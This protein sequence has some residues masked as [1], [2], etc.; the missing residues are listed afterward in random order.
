MKKNVQS[1]NKV[2]KKAN[3]LHK[4]FHIGFVLTCALTISVTMPLAAQNSTEK[5]ID[6]IVAVVNNNV[7]TYQELSAYASLVQKQL[8]GLGNK[9]DV[10]QPAFLKEILERLIIDKIQLQRAKDLG[11]A[12]SEAEFNQILELTTQQNKLSVAEYIAKLEKAGINAKQWKQDQY[13]NIILAR[14][15][16]KEVD[17]L[18][19]VNESEI[20]SYLSSLT[21]VTVAPLEEFNISRIFIPYANSLNK[22]SMNAEELSK[23]R[24]K[25]RQVLEDILAQKITFIQGIRQYSKAP[26]VENKQ[27]ELNINDFSKLPNDV[28][29]VLLRMK[30]QQTWPDLIET[31]DGFY[32]L[33]LNDRKNN[34]ELREKAVQIPQTQVRHI[35][36]RVAGDVNE[37]DAKERLIKIKQRIEAGESMSSLAS[38]YSQDGSAANNGNMGWVNLG[39]MVPEFEQ[40]M[41]V[42][43]LNQISQPIRTDYGYHLIQVLGRRIK[44]VGVNQQRETAKN[45]LIERKTEIVYQDWLRNLRESAFVDYRLQN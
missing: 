2:H 32:I 43:P 19:K 4:V 34:A 45:V 21:G 18:V 38:L 26:E 10:K 28:G 24:E 40:A 23:Q 27:Y 30:R 7:I 6:G 22:D 41:N 13:N 20:D 42:L 36:I 11:I 29:G 9:I 25:S 15:R 5:M 16:Q 3:K 44:S 39:E 31:A 1:Q 17:S 12:I 8:E 37:K 33:R 14:L 35:L